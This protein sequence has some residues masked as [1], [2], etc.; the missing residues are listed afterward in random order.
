M[1]G[2]YN[3]LPD[4]MVTLQTVK[5]FQSKLQLIVKYLAAG[6]YNHWADV[7]SR[8]HIS[9]SVLPSIDE[10][11][12]QNFENSGLAYNLNFRNSRLYNT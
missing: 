2:V 3:L 4:F 7:Y 10:I 9:G 12:L 11:A 1:I 8:E 5:E 6:G